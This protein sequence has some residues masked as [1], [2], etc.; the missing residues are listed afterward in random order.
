MKDHGEEDHSSRLQNAELASL[1]VGEADGP[2]L[3]S[4]EEADGNGWFHLQVI[5]PVACKF[6]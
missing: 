5:V 3:K 6:L 1:A 2:W 4:L